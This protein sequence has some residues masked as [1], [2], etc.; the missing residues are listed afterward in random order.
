MGTVP[1]ILHEIL[2]RNT[3]LYDIIK[4]ASKLDL[5]NYYIGAGCITQTV[6]NHL[7][8][9]DLTH[10][11]SDVDFVYFNHEDLPIHL[12]SDVF[13]IDITNQAK[14]HLWHEDYFG[15]GIEPY[16]SVEHAIDS[17]PTA[18]TAVG[19]RLEGDELKVYA[20]FGLD[21]IFSMTV[22]ANKVKIAEEIYIQKVEKWKK[23]WD[24]LTIIPW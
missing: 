19:V 24:K 5:E 10:G 15:Y 22:R 1:G 9:L 2:K 20:P 7:S 17:W 18:A 8:G 4:Q 11:I 23:K 21:D 12:T 14:V 13:D 3:P 16:T 6:W